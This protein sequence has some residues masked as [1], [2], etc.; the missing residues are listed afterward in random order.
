MPEEHLQIVFDKQKKI[1]K[2]V[3]YPYKNLTN[4][5]LGE[6][7]LKT[8]RTI[9]GDK[10]IDHFYDKNVMK[11]ARQI[12][13]ESVTI[14]INLQRLGVTKGDVVILFSMNN[15]MSAVLTLGCVLL[16]AL[17]NFFEVHMEEGKCN[18]CAV[19]RVH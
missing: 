13:E 10:I 4:T 19:V 15:E 7:F 16:G 6:Q 1:W 14:A 9:D 8:M 18:D 12:Y 5:S 17:P 3:N 2:S 11:T